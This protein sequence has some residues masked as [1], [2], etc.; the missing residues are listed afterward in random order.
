ML[1][2]D[3]DNKFTVTTITII[4]LSSLF[5]LAIFSSIGYHIKINALSA[6]KDKTSSLSPNHRSITKDSKIQILLPSKKEHIGTEPKNFA[7]VKNNSAEALKIAHRLQ[8]TSINGSDTQARFG[9]PCIPEISKFIKPQKE[10]RFTVIKPC[11][12]V[13]GK[14]SWTHYFNDDGDANFNVVLDPQ[15]KDMLGP[16]NYGQAFNIK[17]GVPALHVEVVCQGP[18][19]SLSGENVG[20]CNGYNGPD[21]KHVLPKIGDHV[22]VTGRYLVEMPEMPGGITELHPAYDIRI[23]HAKG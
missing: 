8:I 4:F 18:V 3:N 17:Y 13:T 7:S 11:V 5:V 12:T 22:M 2:N 20:A 10:S 16:G 14:V 6:P 21:F 15:Y 23:L 9:T 1:Y 19:T